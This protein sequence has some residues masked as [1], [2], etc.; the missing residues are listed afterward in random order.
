MDGE[1]SERT[2]TDLM[3]PP[4]Q[5]HDDDAEERITNL[6]LD[7][8]TAVDDHDRLLRTARELGVDPTMVVELEMA[9]NRFLSRLGQYGVTHQPTVGQAFNPT[10]ALQLSVPKRDSPSVGQPLRYS[11]SRRPRFR[12][13]R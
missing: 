8:L 10:F 7:C 4:P 13:H 1:F 9:R 3:M 11:Q 5:M 2:Q 6:L 12:A